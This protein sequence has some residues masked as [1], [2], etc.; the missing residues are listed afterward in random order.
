[1]KSK[2]LWLSLAILFSA[3]NTF[4]QEQDQVLLTI[5]KK[6]VYSSEFVRIL[7]K[8]LH[9][10]DEKPDIE[11]SIDIFINFKLKVKAAEDE[12]I[13]TTEEFIRDL[14]QYRSQLAKPYLMDQ[15]VTKELLDEAWERSQ[16]EYRS[17]H[18]LIGIAKDAS[19]GDTLLAF[20]K[21]ANFK[22]R[23][24]DGE[25]FAELAK[26]VSDDPSARTNGG[27]LGFYTVFDLVYPFENAA[28]N[29][30]VGEVSEP[31][32]T[33]F[34]YHLIK[35]TERIPTRGQIKV[36]IILKSSMYGMS[37]EEHA[38]LKTEIDQI[39]DKLVSGA[40]FGETAMKYSEDKNSGSRGGQLPWF[41]VGNKPKDFE[42]AAFS[43]KN[44]GDFSEPVLTQLGWYIFK[45]I[46]RQIPTR[47][48]MAS[49]FERK[50][51]RDASRSAKSIKVITDRLK[52]EY[53]FSINQKN[54]EEFYRLVDPS[55]FK[56]RWDP[57][58]AL[59][60]KG[61]LFSLNGKDY[62]QAEFA[63]FLTLNMRESREVPIAEFLDKRF[64]SFI[65]TSILAYEE[66]QLDRKY[67]EFRDLYQEFRDGNMLYEVMDKKVWSKASADTVG[68]KDFY[69]TNKDSYLWGERLNGTIIYCKTDLD[70]DKMVDEMHKAVTKYSKSDTSAKALEEVLEEV[71][72]KYSG[73]F[74]LRSGPFSKNENPLTDNIKWKKGV[75]EIIIEDNSRIFVWVRSILEPMPKNLREARGQITA[76]YQDFLDKQWISEL[77]EKY[78]VEI[79]KDVLK[80]IQL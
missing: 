33:E 50:I 72:V 57:N 60:K 31:V 27:D 6:P 45:L 11:E 7:T 40:D 63:K 76:D 35:I 51:S 68:L 70:L 49:T 42:Q 62:L 54:Y 3:I 34:G 43:L 28:Y 56:E 36:A 29:T 53:D 9:H 30:S 14:K 67:P 32:R 20:Q 59:Q 58:P 46:D 71:A 15:K 44:I 41:G 17:S 47:E 74:E 61:V 22:M 52:Q 24:N 69:D 1:M 38:T 4:S 79:N 75:S 55:I 10:Q 18:I 16:V 39:Y 66:T 21:A 64:T 8:N 37:E 73:S 26:E 78:S 2:A 25:D 65:E 5:D 13:D 48:E 80:G 23:L 19:P 77:K 12:G